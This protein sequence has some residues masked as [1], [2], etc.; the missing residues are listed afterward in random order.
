MERGSRLSQRI[1]N[2]RY[3]RV[4]A[5][6]H[7]PGGPC[8]VLERCHGLAE[9]CSAGHAAGVLTRLEVSGGPDPLAAN[10]A[11]CVIA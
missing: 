2:L 3:E 8:R 7:T 11:C 10:M 4:R 9:R 6:E 5:A 1:P